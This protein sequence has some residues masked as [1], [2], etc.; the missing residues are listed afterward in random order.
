MCQGKG[1]KRVRV[2]VWNQVEVREEIETEVEEEGERVRVRDEAE[3]KVR[4]ERERDRVRDEEE[5][6]RVRD[7]EERDKV[8]DEEERDRVTVLREES[9]KRARAESGV[10]MEVIREERT[11]EQMIR[12][13]IRRVERDVEGMVNFQR[14]GEKMKEW[15]GLGC[16]ICWIRGREDQG[17]CQARGGWK[18][19]RQHQ[20]AEGKRM[21]EVIKRVRSIEWERYSGCFQC[22]APQEICCMWEEKTNGGGKSG[23]FIKRQGVGCQFLGVVEEVMAGVISQKVWGWEGMEWEWMEREMR[24]RVGFWGEGGEMEEEERKVWRWVRLKR[25]ENGYDM[26]EGVRMIYFWG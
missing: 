18:E 6:D 3:D 26:S 12:M 11:A 8:R 7:E 2:V 15:S 22:K 20:I 5:R 16:M 13:N 23:R 24:K 9:R 21:E 25:K 10:E 14:L 1:M 19:C 17:N 4:D